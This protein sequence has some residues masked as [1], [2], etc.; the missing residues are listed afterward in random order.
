VAIALRNKTR[1]DTLASVFAGFDV[2]ATDR[3]REYFTNH[4][5]S[6]PSIA[7]LRNGS[8][9]FML[10]RA[11]IEGRDAPEIAADLVR[12]FETF[13]ARPLPA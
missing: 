11:Q 13:C 8:L 4:P 1:P 5:P 12:A 7:L 10:D 9:V 6:S 2:A 3:A